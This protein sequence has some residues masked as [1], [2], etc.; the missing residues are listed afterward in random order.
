M[1]DSSGSQ[2]NNDSSDHS[3]T[4]VTMQNLSNLVQS[5]SIQIVNDINNRYQELCKYEVQVSYLLLIKINT[6]EC[7][8]SSLINVNGGLDIQISG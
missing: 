5:G 8:L 4:M 6:V 2:E 1:N 7:R 3:S